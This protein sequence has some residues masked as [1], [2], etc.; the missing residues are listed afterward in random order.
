M[1]VKT[2]SKSNNNSRSF[3]CEPQSHILTEINNNSNTKDSL[4]SKGK[5]KIVSMAITS[6]ESYGLDNTNSAQKD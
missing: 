2:L 6:F 3:L 4:R 5:K 1:V